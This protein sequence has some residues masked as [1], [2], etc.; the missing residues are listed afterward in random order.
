[1]RDIWTVMLKEWKELSLWDG[2]WSSILS[3]AAFVALIGVFLPWQV[4]PPWI[5]APWV[6]LFWSWMPLF[7]VTTITADSFAGERER[8]TLETLLATRLPDWAILFGKV[9]AA[10]AWV[11]AGTLICL[12]TGVVTVNLSRPTG[13]LLLYEPGG[14]VGIAAVALLAGVLGSALG[15][16]VSLRASSVRQAQQTL[17]VCVLS[18]FMLPLFGLKLLP[19]AWLG[20]LLDLFMAGDTAGVAFAL[21]TVFAAFDAVLLMLALARFQRGR[22]LLD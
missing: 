19:A 8:R 15:V 22:L 1:M 11:W 16:L 7:L 13:G 5:T 9:G 18:F 4:G 21:G 14:V 10:V 20:R 2:G 17:T 3:L 12:P 6:M